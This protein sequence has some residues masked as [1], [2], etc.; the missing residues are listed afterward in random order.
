MSHAR[1]AVAF[2]FSF[3]FLVIPAFAYAQLTCPAGV[4]KVECKVGGAIT[5]ECGKCQQLRK[6][7]DPKSGTLSVQTS[8]T[9]NKE[10]CDVAYLQGPNGTQKC[11]E[12]GI[13]G[14]REE[15]SCKVGGTTCQSL[16]AQAEAAQ[17]SGKTNVPAGGTSQSQPSAPDQKFDQDQAILDAFKDLPPDPDPIRNAADQFNA[18]GDDLEQK[19]NALQRLQDLGVTPKINPSQATLDQDAHNEFFPNALRQALTENALWFSPPDPWDYNWGVQQTVESFGNKPIALPD[20]GTLQISPQGNATFSFPDTPQGLQGATN[21]TNAVNELRGTSGVFGPPIP[22]PTAGSP[23]SFSPALTANPFVASPGGVSPF[24]GTLSPTNLNGQPFSPFSVDPNTKIPYS[25]TEDPAQNANQVFGTPN[26]SALDTNRGIAN[27]KDNLQGAQSGSVPQERQLSVAENVIDGINRGVLP[28]DVYA[29]DAVE[30]VTSAIN[31]GEQVSKQTVEAAQTLAEEALESERAHTISPFF[32]NLKERLGFSE[33]ANRVADLNRAVENNAY[34]KGLQNLAAVDQWVAPESSPRDGIQDVAGS[35]PFQV[36]DSNSGLPDRSS[37]RTQSNVVPGQGETDNTGQPSVGLRGTQM[38]ATDTGTLARERAIRDAQQAYE[39]VRQDVGIDANGND[40]PDLALSPTAKAQLDA[41]RAR[42]VAAENDLVTHRVDYRTSTLNQDPDAVRRLFEQQQQSGTQSGQAQASLTRQERERAAESAAQSQSAQGIIN[43][44]PD[45]VIRQAKAEAGAQSGPAQFSRTTLERMRAEAAQEL[46]DA[47]ARLDTYENVASNGAI[48]NRTPRELNAEAQARAAQESID[49][50]RV[51]EAAAV[52]QQ[53]R[54]ALDVA[55]Q[56]MLDEAARRGVVMVPY[57]TTRTREINEG[58]AMKSIEETVTDYRASTQRL[59]QLTKAHPDYFKD[60]N[61]L[62][63]LQRKEKLAGTGTYA[64]LSAQE[65]QEIRAAEK[66]FAQKYSNVPRG[67]EREQQSLGNTLRA[68]DKKYGP[69]IQRASSAFAEAQGALNAAS[70]QWEQSNAALSEANRMLAAAQPRFD[71]LKEAEA[72]LRTLDA[73]YY[74]RVNDPRNQVP[75]AVARMKAE[76]NRIAQ[77]RAASG[78][79]VRSLNNAGVKKGLAHEKILRARAHFLETEPVQGQVIYDILANDGSRR[80]SPEE[81]AVLNQFDQAALTLFDAKRAFTNEPLTI[82]DPISAELGIVS[83]MPNPAR[84]RYAARIERA[85]DSANN[86]LQHIGYGTDLNA[87]NQLLVDRALGKI[88]PTKFDITAFGNTYSFTFKG[89]ELSDALSTYGEFAANGLLRGP[90]AVLHAPSIFGQEIIRAVWGD[91]AAA[92]AAL[93]TVETVAHLVTGLPKFVYDSASNVAFL[94]GAMNA[95]F[96]DIVARNQYLSPGER[97]AWN[98]LDVAGVTP[99]GTLSKAGYISKARAGLRTLEGRIAAAESI[100]ATAD[101]SS[102]A[103]NA[104]QIAKDSYQ[105]ATADLQRLNNPSVFLNSHRELSQQYATAA[106]NI[107][108]GDGAI[109][110]ALGISDAPAVSSSASARRVVSDIPTSASARLSGDIASEPAWV[111]SLKSAAR[112]ADSAVG[113]PVQSLD[114][115]LGGS[116]DDVFVTSGGVSR[117]SVPS[118]SAVSVL[119]ETPETLDTISSLYR[120][121]QSDAATGARIAEAA[122]YAEAARLFETAAAHARA[123]SLA[124]AEDAIQ[125]GRSISASISLDDLRLARAAGTDKQIVRQAALG[126]TMRALETRDPVLAQKVI[127]GNSLSIAEREIIDQTITQTKAGFGNTDDLVRLLDSEAASVGGTRADVARMIP[128]ADET[129]RSAAVTASAFVPQQ[130]WFTRSQTVQARIQAARQELVAQAR[131][132]AFQNPL[133]TIMEFDAQVA[134]SIGGKS[135]LD[136]Q[137]YGVMA[138]VRGENVV[139]ATSAGKTY[140]VVSSVLAEKALLGERAFIEIAPPN[141]VLGANYITG[142]VGKLK[143]SDM[144][145][146]AGL[147]PYLVKWTP[148]TQAA[149]IAK[150]KGRTSNDVLI[151]DPTTRGHIMTHAKGEGDF[152]LLAALNKSNR[153]TLDEFHNFLGDSS[154]SIRG[155]NAIPPTEAQVSAVDRLLRT[156]GYDRTRVLGE[157]GAT[158][159]AENIRLSKE[160]WLRETFTRSLENDPRR[161]IFTNAEGTNVQLNAAARQYLRENGFANIDVAG[162][163]DNRLIGEVTGRLGRQTEAADGLK[164]SA[165]GKVVPVDAG[166]TAKAGQVP[167]DTY[168]LI[169]FARREGADPFTS[170]SQTHSNAQTPISE[171]YRDVIRNGGEVRGVTATYEG[172]AALQDARIGKGTT[173]LSSSKFDPAQA[174]ILKGGNALQTANDAIRQTLAR[175]AGQRNAYLVFLDDPKL[176]QTYIDNALAKQGPFE[177]LQGKVF[178]LDS[179]GVSI[180]G[181][182][183]PTADFNTLV[184]RGNKTG[185]VFIVNL[186]GTEG[187]NLQGV[188]NGF[189]FGMQGSERMAQTFGRLGRLNPL[190]GKN[191]DT[192]RYLILDEVSEADAIAAA[193]LNPEG[194]AR[195]LRIMENGDGEGSLLFREVVQGRG[196]ALTP[197]QRASLYA[198]L[199]QA[200]AIDASTKGAL[201]AEVRAQSSVRH[202]EDIATDATIAV[203]HQAVARQVLDDL[204]NTPTGVRNFGALREANITNPD[205][206]YLTRLNAS[207]N[208][209]A[210]R[211][212]QELEAGIRATGIAPNR[213]LAAR[214]NTLRS[215]IAERAHLDFNTIRAAESPQAFSQVD[216]VLEHAQLQKRLARTLTSSEEVAVSTNVLATR[217]ESETAR[218]RVAR[219]NPGITD[220]FTAQLFN[221]TALSTSLT[222]FAEEGIGNIVRA[223]FSGTV[224]NAEGL[225]LSAPET[226]TLFGGSGVEPGILV[227]STDVGIRAAVDLGTNDNFIPLSG[228][229]FVEA[230]VQAAATIGTLTPTSDAL[231]FEGARDAVTVVAQSAAPETRPLLNVA[232]R[233]LDRARALAGE[234][235]PGV[236]NIAVS[237]ALQDANAVFNAAFANVASTPSPSVPSAA[238]NVASS[239]AQSVAVR[240]AAPLEQLVVARDTAAFREAYEAMVSAERAVLAAIHQNP[241]AANQS[242]LTAQRAFANARTA[243]QQAARSTENTD[244]TIALNTALGAYDSAMIALFAPASAAPSGVPTVASPSRGGLTEK[245]M[246]N[247]VQVASWLLQRITGVG[248][249]PTSDP[250]PADDS[251]VQLFVEN[252]NTHRQQVAAQTGSV[253]SALGHNMALTNAARM[254]AQFLIEDHNGA[255]HHEVDGTTPETFVILAQYHLNSEGEVVPFNIGENLALEIN[256]PEGTQYERVLQAMLASPPHRALLEN[257]NVNEIGVG[258]FIR[259]GQ[260][261]SVV[262]LGARGGVALEKPIAPSS[263]STTDSLAPIDYNGA[264]LSPSSYTKNITEVQATSIAAELETQTAV[265]TE[266][267]TEFSTVLANAFSGSNLAPVVAALGREATDQQIANLQSTI[268]QRIDALDRMIEIDETVSSKPSF[269]SYKVNLEAAASLLKQNT[270]FLNPEE[271]AAVAAAEDENAKKNVFIQIAQRRLAVADRDREAAREAATNQVDDDDTVPIAQRFKPNVSKD[272]L[273][274]ATKGTQVEAR[275]NAQTQGVVSRLLN[276]WTASMTGLFAGWFGMTA[277]LSDV[278]PTSGQPAVRVVSTMPVLVNEPKLVGEGTLAI[279]VPA[280]RTPIERGERARLIGEILMTHR[281]LSDQLAGGRAITSEQARE[282]LES[283]QELQNELDSRFPDATASEI[284]R[285]F[286]ADLESRVEALAKAVAEKNTEA[287]LYAIKRLREVIEVGLNPDP[288]KRSAA[289]PAFTPLK[290]MAA[291][292]AQMQPTQASEESNNSAV[293]TPVVINALLQAF[294]GKSINQDIVDAVRAGDIQKLRDVANDRERVTDADWENI[295]NALRDAD[296]QVIKAFQEACGRISLIRWLIPIAEAVESNVCAPIANLRSRAALAEFASL[297]EGV[298]IPADLAVIKG[299]VDRYDFFEAT[300]DEYTIAANNESIPTVAATNRTIAKAAQDALTSFRGLMTGT[301]NATKVNLLSLTKDSGDD[302]MEEVAREIDTITQAGITNM[303]GYVAQSFPPLARASPSKTSVDA[304]SPVPDASSGLLRRMWKRVQQIALSA[305]NAAN[306]TAIRGALG[307]VL[308]IAPADSPVQAG[309][310]EPDQPMTNNNLTGGA[311]Q[312]SPFS[313]SFDVYRQRE[314]DTPS[315]PTPKQDNTPASEQ[316]LRSVADS[317]QIMNDGAPAE[318]RAFVNGGVEALERARLATNPADKIIP[319]I[320]TD[321]NRFFQYRALGD[322]TYI[323]DGIEHTIPNAVGQYRSSGVLSSIFNINSGSAISVG[324]QLSAPQALARARAG[325]T[326]PTDDFYDLAQDPDALTKI[327]I[328][329]QFFTARESFNKLT[330]EKTAADTKVINDFIAAQGAL[331]RAGLQWGGEQDP[332]GF[333]TIYRANPDGTRGQPIVRLNSDG[334]MMFKRLVRSD[335][336]GAEAGAVPEQVVAPQEVNRN[337]IVQNI[338]EKGVARN[339]A[340][341]FAARAQSL[342]LPVFGGALALLFDIDPTLAAD[343]GSLI[344]ATTQGIFGTDL[345]PILATLGIMPAVDAPEIKS[346]TAPNISTVDEILS[347]MQALRAGEGGV[348]GVSTT[349]LPNTRLPVLNEEV[350]NRLLVARAAL[351]VDAAD[352]PGTALARELVQRQ[353]I[354]KVLEQQVETEI[355]RGGLSFLEFLMVNEMLAELLAID[356]SLTDRTNFYNIPRRL[357]ANWFTNISGKWTQLSKP[358]ITGFNNDAGLYEFPTTEGIFTIEDGMRAL[359]AGVHL[360]GVGRGRVDADGFVKADGSPDPLDAIRLLYHDLAHGEIITYMYAGTNQTG[361][362]S[363]PAAVLEGFQ[364][365]SSDWVAR[366]SSVDTSIRN[367]VNPILWLAW[368]EGEDMPRSA[369]DAFRNRYLL[370]GNYAAIDALFARLSTSFNAPLQTAPRALSR[371]FDERDLRGTLP[372]FLGSVPRDAATDEQIQQYLLQALAVWRDQMS[373]SAFESGVEVISRASSDATLGTSKP[374]SIVVHP[375]AP[376]LAAIGSLGDCLTLI[377]A[378]LGNGEIGEAA[379]N[380]GNIAAAAIEPMGLHTVRSGATTAGVLSNPDSSSALVP[381]T[382]STATRILQGAGNNAA[383]KLIAQRI[384]A[385]HA[386]SDHQAQFENYFQN[387]IGKRG[388]ANIISETIRHAPHYAE[389]AYTEGKEYIFYNPANR[390]VVVY[391]A[392]PGKIGTAFI[393]FESNPLKGVAG[394]PLRND[395]ARRILEKKGERRLVQEGVPVRLSSSEGEN[396]QSFINYIASRVARG[397][398]KKVEGGFEYHIVEPNGTVFVATY[399]PRNPAQDDFRKVSP[400]QTEKAEGMI[401]LLSALENR[402]GDIVVTTYTRGGQSYQAR[403]QITR[404][405]GQGFSAA[406]GVYEAEVLKSNDLTVGS[407]V[408][409][410]FFDPLNDTFSSRELQHEQLGFDVARQAGLP[411]ATLYGIDRDNALMISENLNSGGFVAL[412][413][414]N[415]N[416]L[417]PTNSIPAIENFSDVVRELFSI[418]ETAR[419]EGVY[420]P[421]DSYFALVPVENSVMPVPMRFVIGDYA[422]V[423]QDSVKSNRNHEFARMFLNNFIDAWI[424]QENTRAAYHAIVESAYAVNN[425]CSITTLPNVAQLAAGGVLP[426]VLDTAQAVQSGEG[427]RVL[428]NADAVTRSA[429]QRGVLTLLPESLRNI[430]KI[431]YPAARLLVGTPDVPVIAQGASQ[432][433]RSVRQPN[434]RNTLVQSPVRSAAAALA[435]MFGFATEPGSAVAGDA[436]SQQTVSQERLD[437][438]GDLIRD[439]AK[440]PL[441][442][443]AWSTQVGKDGGLPLRQRVGIEKAPLWALDDQIIIAHAQKTLALYNNEGRK[444]FRALRLPA[445][446]WQD[447]TLEMGRNGTARIDY[448]HE[449]RH[450]TFDLDAFVKHRGLLA[451]K[452]VA[453]LETIDVILAH[454]FGHH[455]QVHLLQTPQASFGFVASR[456]GIHSQ[457]GEAQADFFAG[458]I[459]RNWV[460]LRAANF[461]NSDNG[462]IG[463][464]TDLDIFGLVFRAIGNPLH[465]VDPQLGLSNTGTHPGGVRRTT[466]FY[467][468]LVGEFVEGLAIFPL[469][470]LQMLT[471]IAPDNVATLNKSGFEFY[472]ANKNIFTE[473]GMRALRN[474]AV[475]NRSSGTIIGKAAAEWLASVSENKN[476][477]F[478]SRVLEAQTFIRR[479]L[480]AGVAVDNASAPQP[481]NAPGGNQSPARAPMQRGSTRT[482]EL[483][484]KNSDIARELIPPEDLKT[485]DRIYAIVNELQERAAVLDD[486]AYDALFEIIVALQNMAAPFDKGSSQPLPTNKH[487][488]VLAEA[489]RLRNEGLALFKESTLEVGVLQPDIGSDPCA[490]VAENLSQLAAAG[491]LA[492][493]DQAPCVNNILNDKDMGAQLKL[494]DLLETRGVSVVSARRAVNAWRTNPN[495]ARVAVNNAIKKLGNAKL[496]QQLLS[497]AGITVSLADAFKSINLDD[498]ANDAAIEAFNKRMEEQRMRDGLIAQPGVVPSTNKPLT[499]RLEAHAPRKSTPLSVRA[500]D[501]EFTMPALFQTREEKERRAAAS[502]GAGVSSPFAFGGMLRGDSIAARASE[503]L[504]PEPGIRARIG[505]AFRGFFTRSGS[506]PQETLPSTATNDQPAIPSPSDESSGVSAGDAQPQPSSA[507]SM[508]KAGED[509]AAVQKQLD[510]IIAG[511]SAFTQKEAAAR[512]PAPPSRTGNFVRNVGNI[513]AAPFAA[514]SSMKKVVTVPL[515]AA[516]VMTTFPKYGVG[517]ALD[518]MPLIKRLSIGKKMQAPH[519]SA[520]SEMKAART[521]EPVTAGKIRTSFERTAVRLDTV[522]AW[523]GKASNWIASKTSRRRTP[524]QTNEKSPEITLAPASVAQPK[525]VETPIAATSKDSIAAAPPQ[526]DSYLPRILRKLPPPPPPGGSGVPPENPWWRRTAAFLILILSTLIAGDDAQTIPEPRQADSKEGTTPPPAPVSPSESPAPVPPATDPPATEPPAAPAP[527]TEPKT[528][529]PAQ[530]APEPEAPPAWTEDGDPKAREKAVTPEDEKRLAELRNP[531][532]SRKDVRTRGAGPG[533]R[534]QPPSGGS[535]LGGGG[536]LGGLGGGGS[537]LSGLLAALADYFNTAAPEETPLETAA[538]G[539]LPSPLP[540]PTITKTP[541]QLNPVVSVIV[542]NPSLI[543]NGTSTRLT[544]SS[545]GT[546]VG[547]TTCAIISEN[548]EILTQGGRNGTLYSPVLFESTRFGLVCN[549]PKRVFTSTGIPIQLA[550]AGAASILDTAVHGKIINEILVRVRGDDTDPPPIFSDEILR[551][552]PYGVVVGGGTGSGARPSQTDGT[553]GSASGSFVRAQGGESS[554]GASGS[555]PN[556]VRVCD[557]E[558]PIRAFIRCLCEVEPNPAGCTIPVGGL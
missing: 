526:G 83:E 517:W 155:A 529:P 85:R 364:K 78:V 356:T 50:R 365:I 167:K 418:A 121:A 34:T 132:G 482:S 186:R 558:Q 116:G 224:N 81:Q 335:L 502:R 59:E 297:R 42:V 101:R 11:W 222:P 39:S 447:A 17:K 245:A 389:I 439:V 402:T 169:A 15:P 197:T 264:V 97:F 399:Y 282:A 400:T 420:L 252:T 73:A 474:F 405:I 539:P 56:K 255:L 533:V 440:E 14:D 431:A 436:P 382:N 315:I 77:N 206:A 289:I 244:V 153:V 201:A 346:D 523:V 159:F 44:D 89:Q 150:I 111:T 345:T 488:V 394:I 23:F 330:Q 349:F 358:F 445:S 88:E 313:F 30:K 241:A 392:R 536:G 551:T 68:L 514:G 156:M 348:P 543:E 360:V 505:A 74:A 160:E 145:R 438:I 135:L 95:P 375:N 16:K 40:L 485:Y 492:A 322:I 53:R 106:K 298:S 427:G 120:L 527:K 347:T 251:G 126:N 437:P 540:K 556:D 202:L 317:G 501:Q 368:H 52:A 448:T 288:K 115:L 424:A 117:V 454:E 370:P 175:G 127:N 411:T 194:Y 494:L 489:E 162:S 463:R 419:S 189:V 415:A 367:Q 82:P 147:E 537:L 64:P 306:Q 393:N 263:E 232:A 412:S 118:R 326:A 332:S 161:L 187:V 278:P 429:A 204:N 548:F 212:L 386:F 555:T 165:E 136:G 329:D 550:A 396:T 170:V 274:S 530:P 446:A 451:L 100:L 223:K 338:P 277:I 112:A 404:G 301:S 158:T 248:N 544:W 21:F 473:E 314:I 384:V 483:R 304:T 192:A 342:V 107:S 203:E 442:G 4:P 10:E 261:V 54:A 199:K 94:A 506:V 363:V 286:K 173:Y 2:C 471:Y 541:I 190:T 103:F 221:T 134:R 254:K 270:V 258:S 480:F 416:A 324:E 352:Y 253:L 493:G 334:T 428:E 242:I 266:T 35:N 139:A 311:P 433:V 538:P 130:G 180:N 12:A 285:R 99:W 196:E 323:L 376:Q 38:G 237:R 337:P 275:S 443:D 510:V 109:S 48:V 207:E 276:T 369:S 105:K 387:R 491:G 172:V 24:G 294:E 33:A 522:S 383:R 320:T 410:K 450:I 472:I 262:L 475:R 308:A 228:E 406:G 181:V 157:S 390:V 554:S 462:E 500:D 293:L 545:I 398:V 152:Q 198:K 91:D 413:G 340:E 216:S 195:A 163:V 300:F 267:N 292:P 218:T 381:Q 215:Q 403:L 373:I 532:P 191:W 247:A 467:E 114:T 414:N 513:I 305:W 182:P 426:C 504:S 137:R 6:I 20:G 185:D 32:Q 184:N 8:Q 13:Q 511:L 455:L 209:V 217:V 7:I 380:I 98:T 519:L 542:A 92:W 46:K 9:G 379:R 28:K 299:F 535:D 151:I 113:S 96:A 129:I 302:V 49:A 465:A 45:A 354:L 496:A 188:F 497:E 385:D 146:S 521:A 333:P 328:A 1:Y 102:S 29:A 26:D 481:A 214:M 200:D 246:G 401:E 176:M 5:T 318:E 143:F 553:T 140:T 331:I 281:V 220:S 164:I 66:A 296:A 366:A 233:A 291:P 350:R 557:P 235:A 391:D 110:R 168:G 280:F 351:P 37:G 449:A 516:R 549:I 422:G 260:R 359:A 353:Q 90:L 229:A 47:R 361:Q 407:T 372:E 144:Y 80:I 310:P 71:A 131:A 93:P 388:L 75:D 487:T 518:R 409:V 507:P 312:D 219:L 25:T 210:Q 72:N 67:V 133:L 444:L 174:T 371:F 87:D 171:I 309:L 18:A 321:R 279:E 339:I 479:Q 546:E 525:G 374:C 287:R 408:I 27:P 325:I 51:A 456:D 534:T 290:Q 434:F 249:A 273:A 295:I 528:D 272:P 355:D 378:Q 239:R 460:G 327:E 552:L 423:S 468:G 61:V 211:V 344:Q 65:K 84:D 119:G 226:T 459:V 417:I 432:V 124:A 477:V 271:G 63:A 69:E 213:A 166:G 464:P 441:I 515:R 268:N 547:S 435:L 86:L 108:S 141:T 499:A 123:G 70:K 495:E 397:A 243:L 498:D 486:D 265:A 470:E 259:N 36:A 336:G 205:V 357:P 58:G 458:F 257:P 125:T 31:R 225:Y 362:G 303:R 43:Q 478:V 234:Q 508:G 193:R 122:R 148:E 503:S 395:F 531:T 79:L 377:G 76:A 19:I 469:F 457:S 154:A 22:A 57:E 250:F 453:G 509:S 425:P 283:R 230:Q 490:V 476:E 60:S 316:P 41:A 104:A 178:V 452:D 341:R 461:G 55:N 430:G 343:P 466:V 149:D 512:A 138:L 524:A 227:G 421:A 269:T 177:G 319:L 307:I 284:E 238:Q 3:V 231:A 179:E 484:T 208:A 183:Q 240:G 256:V 520:I 128:Q 236:T 142:S 62:G